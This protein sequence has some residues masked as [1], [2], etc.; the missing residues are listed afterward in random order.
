MK[1]LNS[2]LFFWLRDESRIIKSIVLTKVQF[3]DWCIYLINRTLTITAQ[4]YL[5]GYVNS[6]EG[7]TG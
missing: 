7:V 1:L 2:L 6:V 4:H 5:L 3:C